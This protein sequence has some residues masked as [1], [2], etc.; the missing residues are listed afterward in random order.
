M[1]RRNATLPTHHDFGADGGSGPASLTQ[2]SSKVVNR[3]PECAGGR[4]TRIAMV[5]TD[6]SP[7][8]FTSCHTCEHRSWVQHGSALPIDT[9]L[10]KTRKPR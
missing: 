5:L 7:V 2:V 6:G 10:A 9:V 4:L 1:P 3:C 8:E